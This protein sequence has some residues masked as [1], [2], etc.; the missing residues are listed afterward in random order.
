MANACFTQIHPTCIPVSGDYQSKLTL[1]S[2]SLRND[3]R[4]WVPKNK[5]DAEAIRAGHLAPTDLKEEDRD[6]YLERRYPAFG[7][8]VPRDVASR[9]A[10]IV[11]D[12][13]YGVNAAG[14]AVFLDFEA[15]IL[16]YGKTEASTHGHHHPDDATIRKLGE[17][18]VSELYGN[19]F[20]MYEKIT[21]DNPYNTPMMIYPA[22]HYTMGGL[23]VD[24]NLETN[25]PGLF[26]LGECNF[27]DH[28]ANRLGA[29][30]LMQ[31]LADG[32]FVIPYTIGTFL[33]NEIRTPRFQTDTEEFKSTEQAVEDRINRLMNVGGDQSVEDFHRR[34]GHIMWDYC[35]MARNAEGL[36]KAK[37]LVRQL[38]EEFYQHVFVPGNS[39]DFNPEL[40]KAYRVADFL[41]MGELMIHD[42]LSRHESCGGHFREEYQ[43]ADG[44]AL[45]NDEDFTYVAS[46][47]WTDTNQ[48]PVM[49]K[50]ELRFENVELKTRSYK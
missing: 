9:A 16:R 11:C 14:L 10:K 28:G 6:Y 38:R 44:E 33:A 5:A 31:G 47:E 20:E 8:L 49:H 15:A 23:W 42:A 4:V 18:K 37:T 34:L 7:N 24:Y 40:E 41:E 26:A 29:S 36:E 39:D 30:A 25:I 35:G 2:E 32:Y 17:A 46:W 48:A 19:L 3:G 12:E 27:S 13:G 22:I 21:G 45:R 50:E 1:M 43:S